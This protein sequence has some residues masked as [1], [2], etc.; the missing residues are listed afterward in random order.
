MADIAEQHEA[1]LQRDAS[2]SD[3]SDGENSSSGGG[4]DDNGPQ[5]GG[6]HQT[7]GDQDGDDDNGDGVG[8]SGGGGT[9]PEESQQA[10]LRDLAEVARQLDLP[11]ASI[12]RPLVVAAQKREASGHQQHHRMDSHTGDGYDNDKSIDAEG[13]PLVIAVSADHAVCYPDGSTAKCRM[14]DS[15]RVSGVGAS[16]LQIPSAFV[17]NSTSSGSEPVIP[18][19]RMKISL[20]SHEVEQLLRDCD[21]GDDDNHNDDAAALGGAAAHHRTFSS[22]AGGGTNSGT[23]GERPASRSAADGGAAPSHSARTIPY[24]SSSSDRQLEASPDSH[25]PCGTGSVRDS[26]GVPTIP[27]RAKQVSGLQRSGAAV[28]ASSSL[29]SSKRVGFASAEVQTVHVY[30]VDNSLFISIHYARPLFGWLVLFLAVIFGCTSDVINIHH[31]GRDDSGAYIYA[32][33]SSMG[34]LA[35]AVIGLP[36]WIVSVRPSKAEAVFLSSRDGVLLVLLCGTVGAL[37]K[38]AQQAAAHIT[39]EWR[40]LSFS[41]VHPVLIVLF[42]KLFRNVVFFEE[43]V[44]SAFMLAGFV[45][46]LLAADTALDRWPFAEVVALSQG[47][48]IASFLFLAV[49][50]RGKRVSIVVV[51]AAVAFVHALTQVAVCL[52]TNQNFA[53]RTATRLGVFDF[54][55]SDVFGTWLLESS[56][57]TFSLLCYLMT[58]KFIPPLTVSAAM[59]IQV[60]FSQLASYMM[61]FNES[62]ALWSLCPASNLPSMLATPS[63]TAAAFTVEVTQYCGNNKNGDNNIRNTLFAIGSCICVLAA[64]YL[65]YVSSIKRSKVDMMLRHLS[66]RKVPRNPYKKKI[67]VHGGQQNEGRFLLRPGSGS[68]RIPAGNSPHG[69]RYSSSAS[70]T[71]ARHYRGHSG[72]HGAD[73]S[74]LRTMSSSG[75]LSSPDERDGFAGL[76]RSSREA[77][78]TT[79]NE[80]EADAKVI[81]ASVSDAGVVPCVQQQPARRT[82]PSTT[83]KRNSSLRVVVRKATGTAVKRNAATTSPPTALPSMVAGNRLDA[84]YDDA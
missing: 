5:P 82:S 62:T 36:T 64:G 3:N 65:L 84:Y 44:G 67:D 41:A 22:A 9:S 31:M 43:A 76:R 57:A 47:I 56:S 15:T 83:G 63:P 61:L 74:S 46:A 4:G 51:A 59:C 25:H 69:R 66:Q 78:A 38:L 45:V 21:D 10:F 23:L 81:V 27:I 39:Q 68:G 50:L 37:A 48:Y 71:D 80:R 55:Q 58:L 72:S 20:S 32:T 42:G 17:A 35:F 14:Y 54:L 77:A 29:S 16:S 2:C 24:S 70:P 18:V 8:G 6:E 75:S 28:I 53:I 26:V 13:A 34:L 73:S 52:V 11:V 1:L 30:E 7:T 33:W 49:K 12:I 79:A 60:M 19:R 40:W